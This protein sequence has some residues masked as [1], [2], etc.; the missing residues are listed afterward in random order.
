MWERGGPSVTAG[1]DV[2]QYLQCCGHQQGGFSKKITSRR[3]RDPAIHT[4]EDRPGGPRARAPLQRHQH[5]LL[6][7]ALFIMI[8]LQNQ[9]RWLA[10]DE[11]TT[12]NGFIPFARQWM[13][14]QTLHLSDISQIFKNR[15]LLITVL[16]FVCLM[17][18]LSHY[19]TS[20]GLDFTM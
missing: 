3:M 18:C 19:I 20:D 6:Y 12:K 2:R 15:E 11:W 16:L 7:T 4:L 9:G 13:T 14:L 10:T 8:K 17:Y 1:G 5:T